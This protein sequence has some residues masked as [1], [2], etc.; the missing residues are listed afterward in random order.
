MFEN[1]VG[2]FALFLVPPPPPASL[3]GAFPLALVV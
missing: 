1:G 2:D 3:V